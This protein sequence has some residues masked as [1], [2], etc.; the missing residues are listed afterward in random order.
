MSEALLEPGPALGN[1]HRIL[2]ALPTGRTLEVRT[3]DR[4]GESFRA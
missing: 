2:Q 4:T 1:V 3:T